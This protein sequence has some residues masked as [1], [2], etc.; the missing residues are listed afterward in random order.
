MA[1]LASFSKQNDRRQLTARLC[2]FTRA[3]GALCARVVGAPTGWALADLPAHRA[4]YQ[5]AGLA[6]IVQG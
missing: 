4:R 1:R 6:A 2:D 3:R 5:H